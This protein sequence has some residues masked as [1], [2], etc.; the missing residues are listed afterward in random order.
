MC[1]H[2]WKCSQNDCDE[3]SLFR[4]GH[5]YRVL[6]YEMPLNTN[7]LLSGAS[8]QMVTN[9][10]STNQDMTTTPALLEAV[11]QLNEKGFVRGRAS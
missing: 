4:R 10:I 8:A 1:Q 6:A 3:Q 7:A 11:F 2:M 5:P 9:R